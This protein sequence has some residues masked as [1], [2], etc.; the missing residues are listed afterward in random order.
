M[1][2]IKS[3]EM[4]CVGCKKSKYTF[5]TTEHVLSPFLCPLCNL[6]FSM[7]INK[8]KDGIKL[9]NQGIELLKDSEIVFL[10]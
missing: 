9:I 1:K 2:K 7:P 4:S 8:C 10:E 6:D 5:E 3:F